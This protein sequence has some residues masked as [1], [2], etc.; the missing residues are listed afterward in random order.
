MGCSCDGL[1]KKFMGFSWQTG[2]YSHWTVVGVLNLYCFMAEQV[3]Q[4]RTG[5]MA[6]PNLVDLE[7]CPGMCEV[8]FLT[9]LIIFT[10]IPRSL[11]E[12]SP[13]RP[14]S[15]CSDSSQSCSQCVFLMTPKA[16]HYHRA[17]SSFWLVSLSG[18]WIMAWIA[19]TIVDHFPACD[20]MRRI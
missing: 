19:S 16:N 3:P 7:F 9:D 5:K 1:H 6:V 18:A 8:E 17:S 11:L 2:H 4:Y 15:W 20:C 10:D 13:S 14:V 12:N